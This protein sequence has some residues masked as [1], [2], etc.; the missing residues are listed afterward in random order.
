MSVE[1]ACTVAKEDQPCG[2][3]RVTSGDV[4]SYARKKYSRYPAK[5]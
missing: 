5:E 3:I 1:P 2:V 4:A